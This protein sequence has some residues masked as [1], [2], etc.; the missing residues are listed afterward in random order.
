MTTP[1]A[2]DR[3]GGITFVVVLAYIGFIFEILAGILIMIEADEVSQQLRSGMTEDQMMAAGIVTVVIGVIGVLL[4]GALARGS[5]V[6]RILF[7]VWVAFQVAG[8]LYAMLSH[9]GVRRG[10]GIV[11]VVFG[12]VIL[13]LLFNQRAHDYFAK[14]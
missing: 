6:V 14:D 3:P 12:I 1:E 2:T 13:Y 7:G 10:A 9:D 8:G 4:T 11:P 5:N